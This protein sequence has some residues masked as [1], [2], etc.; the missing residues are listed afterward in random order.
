M[1]KGA[2]LHGDK[3]YESTDITNSRLDRMYNDTYNPDL[4]DL[5]HALTVGQKDKI[6]SDMNAIYAMSLSELQELA[7]TDLLFSGPQRIIKFVREPNQKTPPMIDIVFS[8]EQISI[9]YATFQNE[10][11]GK[12][13]R[14][15]ESIYDLEEFLG[16]ANRDY[17][18]AYLTDLKAGL[19]NSL[20]ARWIPTETSVSALQ[21]NYYGIAL[22]QALVNIGFNNYDQVMT[23]E[24]LQ[25]FMRGFFEHMMGDYEKLRAYLLDTYVLNNFFFIGLEDLSELISELKQFGLDVFVPY[26]IANANTSIEKLG[27]A[28]IENL[29]PEFINRIYIDKYVTEDSKYRVER[30]VDNVLG[31]YTNMFSNSTWLSEKTKLRAIEKLEKMTNTVFYDEELLRLDPIDFT[32]LDENHLLSS[33]LEYEKYV[34]DGIYAGNLST[35]ELNSYYHPYTVNA[36]YSNQSNTF[37]VFHGILS[38]FIDNPNLSEEELLGTIGFII[39]HEISHAFDNTGSQYWQGQLV[40]WWEPE[41]KYRFNQ[42]VEKL[43][44]YINTNIETL[45]DTQIRGGNIAGE[46][47]ADMGAMRVM[48]DLAKGYTN[49]KLD[50]FFRAF[51]QF[52]SVVY[53]LKEAQRRN[54]ED[55]HAAS[56]IRVNLTLIQFEEFRNCYNITLGDGMYIDPEDV[57]AIW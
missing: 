13:I 24:G 6:L 25:E 1:P 27:R 46:V 17:E 19:A 43:I 49:F 15:I 52:W 32:S 29:F 5:M 47:I 10:Y 37:S 35:N 42:K 14:I 41:D 7:L 50:K 53:T 40:D 30:I 38:S 8:N 22:D 3:I 12:N 51:T 21:S 57:I 31:N 11:Y 36:A 34:R 44:N 18:R 9:A 4:H 23:T 56:Y 16:F 54:E 55:V 33:Y 39:G 2:A 28:I 20:N 26:P 45:K 48:L